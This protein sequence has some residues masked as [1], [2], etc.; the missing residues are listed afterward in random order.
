MTASPDGSRI[1]VGGDFTQA[2]GQTRNRVAAYDTAT[3]AL[4]GTLGSPSVNSQVRAIAVTADTVY[5]GGSITA[6]GGGQPHPAGRGQR[7]RRRPPALGAGA[8]RRRRPPRRQHDQRRAWRWSSPAAAP[9]S[10]PPAGSPR[11]N[12]VKATGVAALDAVTGANRPVRDQPAAHQPGRQLRRLQPHH[13]RRRTSTAPA[14]TSAARATSRAPSSRRPTA[15]RSWRSTT[16]AATPTRATPPAA[17]CTSP[18]TRTTAA[19]SAASRSRAPGCTSSPPRSRPRRP[20]RSADDVHQRELR[21]PAGAGAA[22]LVPDMT[23]GTFTGQNQAGWS[24]TGNGQYVVYGGEFPRVNGVDQQGLVRFA[25]PARRAERGRPGRRRLRR[26]PSP[27]RPGWRRSPGRPPDDQ[28]NEYLTYRV[29]RDGVAA[30]VYPDHGGFPVVEHA[31]MSAADAGVSRLAALPRR[32]DRPVRQPGHRA[33]TS[34]EVA[35]GGRATGRTLPDVVRADGATDQWRLGEASGTR[36][37]RQRRRSTMT[38]GYGRRRGAS[39]GRSRATRTPRSTLSDGTGRP[40]AHRARRPARTSS[41]VEAWFQTTS[42]SGGKIL[43]FGN[44]ASGTA[45]PTTGT[46]TWTRRASVIF[47]VAPTGSPSGRSPARRRFNDGKWHHVAASLSSAGMALYV[48][49]KL[50]RVAPTPPSARLQRL[51]PDRRRPPV[52]GDAEPSPAGSTRSPS[53]RRRS[54]PTRCAA[55]TPR[56]RRRSGQRRADGLLR[57]HGDGLAATFD[58]AASADADGTLATYAWDFGDGSTGTGATAA[59]TY[60]A[61]RHLPGTLTVTDDTGAQATRPAGVSDRARGA[62]P[63]ADRGVHPHRRPDGLGRRVGVRRRRRPVAGLRVELRGRAVHRHRR[64]R[65]ARYAAAGPTR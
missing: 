25:V 56:A 40:R 3:G 24:V 15:A 47:G 61:R 22:R 26:R 27:R 58:A 17:R 34:V 11:M 57:R 63:G 35:P 48:D 14:T 5:L 6:V 49:G 16:A 13:R 60:A 46:S 18:A 55:T 19:T 9:R 8:R 7:R 29:Y 2:D 44:C 21:R 38:V 30:P 50:W 51:L 59:H 39:P 4:V 45:R 12:G 65:R 53:T 41:R 33:W 62:E 42:T 1:Y 23:P 20:A 32:G 28:D 43:G 37:R 54:T 31:A 52:G 36:A 64:R 10:W